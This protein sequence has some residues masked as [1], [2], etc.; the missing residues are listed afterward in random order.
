MRRS[1]FVLGLAFV[2]SCSADA[3]L[4]ADPVINSGGDLVQRPFTPEELDILVDDRG[5]PYDS[6]SQR[7]GPERLEA[8]SLGRFFVPG[9]HLAVMDGISALLDPGFWAD[10]AILVDFD[11][12]SLEVSIIWERFSRGYD[13]VFAVRV[14]RPGSIVTAW[15]PLEY[16]YGTDGGMGAIVSQSTI[17]AAILAQ[18][19]DDWYIGAE[20]DW[21]QDTYLFDLD[22]RPGNDLLAFSNGYGDGAFPMT[23]GLDLD[24]RLASLVIFDMG[25]NPWRR[26]F[27]I[28]T[29]PPDVIEREEELIECLAGERPV[30]QYETSQWCTSDV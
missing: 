12:E 15:Q 21:G 5:R 28:G 7:Y 9:G 23:R 22:G 26:A 20:P 16:A 27:P 13:A 3:P 30:R 10:E 1:A 17:D 14:D 29:P 18:P 8:E 6:G 25:R 2:A 4:D 19:V 24:G 11:V